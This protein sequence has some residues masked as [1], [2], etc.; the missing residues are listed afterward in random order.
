MIFMNIIVVGAKKEAVSGGT[1]ASYWNNPEQAKHSDLVELK[2]LFECDVLCYDLAY[3]YDKEVDGIK[4]ISNI[5]Y[6]DGEG[7]VADRLN[8]IIEF[9][10]MLDENYINH[11]DG[12]PQQLN[13]T[14]LVEMSE[15]KIAILACGCSWNK[16]FPLD[17]ISCIYERG[18]YTPC[19]A[20]NV[21]NLLYVLSCTDCIRTLTEKEQ[22]MLYPYQ[23]GV[24]QVMGTFMW[25][26]CE[27]DNYK[28]ECVLR[29]LFSLIS[30]DCMDEING[31]KKEDLLDFIHGKKHW[32]NMQWQMRKALSK[33]VYGF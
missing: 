32:N 33:F 11:G 20:Y 4:Y 18:F 6:L 12:N 15:F 25:R 2:T 7:L 26:G 17:C 30:A 5:F 19:D 31:V 16:G 23:Q 22:E 24:Y 29:E 13:L 14:K 10:N 1:D 3:P 8:V 9:N 27:T 28:S 21:D